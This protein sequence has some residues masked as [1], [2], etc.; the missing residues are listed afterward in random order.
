MINR[1][2]STTQPGLYFWAEKQCC[3]SYIVFSQV[4]GYPA[5]EDLQPNGL[6]NGEELFYLI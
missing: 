2:E 6:P 5:T 3:N 4:N 1:Y